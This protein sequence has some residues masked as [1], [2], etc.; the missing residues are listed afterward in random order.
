MTDERKKK[1]LKAALAVIDKEVGK[2]V[3]GTVGHLKNVLPPSY[4]TGSLRLDLAIGI[5]GLPMG[6][7]IE[8]FGDESTCKTTLALQVIAAVQKQGGVGVFIDAE[9]ALYEPYAG[10]LGCD[11]DEL[12]VSKPESGEQAFGIIERLLLA[13]AA[14]VIVVDSVSALIPKSERDD[15]IGSDHSSDQARLMS[16]ALR[17]LTPL[18]KESDCLLIFINQIRFNTQTQR[19]TTSGGNA[20]HFYAS[21]RIEMKLIEDLPGNSGIRGVRVEATMRKNKVGPKNQVAVVDFLVNTGADKP[22]EL[23]DL[24]LEYKVF[25][26]AAKC[27]TFQGTTL[28]AKSTEARQFI[29]SHPDVAALIEDEIRHVALSWKPAQPVE[30]EHA[31]AE[32][33]VA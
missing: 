33:E 20:L 1:A 14:N 21:V 24:G 16:Q 2:G 4:T 30:A 6:R 26:N 11:L 27:I 3:L 7:I 13:K 18:V 32:T 29:A 5:G 28:G 19:E 10:S 9:H 31:E 15:V 17:K 8:I 12:L 22:T 23:V 25:G